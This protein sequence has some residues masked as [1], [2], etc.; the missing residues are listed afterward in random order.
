MVGEVSHDY[1]EGVGNPILD[2]IAAVL[3]DGPTAIPNTRKVRTASQPRLQGTP[4]KQVDALGK[5]QADNRGRNKRQVIL[6]D[7]GR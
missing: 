7:T 1:I 4:G 2:S 6:L 5:H 3:N